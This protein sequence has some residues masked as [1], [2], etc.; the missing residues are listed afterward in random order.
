MDVYVGPSKTD[1]VKCEGD[2]FDGYG[3][4]FYNN[5]GDVYEGYFKEGEFHGKGKGS[6]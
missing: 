3:K 5:Y 6:Q 1:N 2:C 4:L